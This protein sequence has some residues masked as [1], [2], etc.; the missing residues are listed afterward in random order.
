MIRG[1]IFDFDGVILESVNV[2]TEA[3]RRLFAGCPE[4]IDAIVDYHLCNTGVSRFDK[5]RY[6][7]ANLLNEP[8]SEE[9]FCSLC[10]RFAD[11]VVEEVVGCDFVRG[12]KEFLEKYHR[13]L[14]LFIVSG[15]PQDEMRLI[16]ERKGMKH[17]FADVLGSPEKK[18]VLVKKILIEYQ[19]NP[20]D[21]VFVGDSL[22]DYEGA[23][24]CGVQFVGRVVSQ[25]NHI[26]NGLEIEDTVVDLSEL[27]DLLYKIDK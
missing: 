17:Y 23:Q 1:I 2:K 8:L 14:L 21:M 22:S 27:D 10:D 3:F 18:G 25:D 4:H 16:V 26:F 9:R 24:E 7:Y 6:I 19:L 13:R 12:A 11:L 15:T 5:F 20:D